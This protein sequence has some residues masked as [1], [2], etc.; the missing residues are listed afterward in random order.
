MLTQHIALVPEAYGL[1][2]SDLA[3]VS[4]ALQKQVTRDFTPIWGISATVDAFPRMEDV[5]IGYWPIVV[6]FNDLGRRAGVHLDRNGQPF[7]LIEVTPCWSLQA[8]RACLEMLVNPSGNRTV[9]TMPARAGQ[10]PA[11]LL[12][13][14]CGPCKDPRYAY[15]I[16]DVL[17]SDFC[18]PA[19]YGESRSV[20]PQRY[21][22]TGAIDAPFQVLPGGHA[23]WYDALTDSWWSK[24]YD[25][26]CQAETKLELGAF[27]VITRHEWMPNVA[28]LSLQTRVM[29]L[30]GLEAKTAERNHRAVLA[31]QMRAHR[32]RADLAAYL[33]D[34]DASQL[35]APRAHEALPSRAA[36]PINEQTV[37]LDEAVAV[38]ADEVKDVAPSS[39]EVFARV[40]SAPPPLPSVAPS[41]APSAAPP[42]RLQAPQPLA[43]RAWTAGRTGVLLAVGA[44]A[45]VGLL[46]LLPTPQSHVRS[47]REANALPAYAS[48]PD[49]RPTAAPAL[50]AA[51]PAAPAIAAA[52]EPTTKSAA[53]R[54]AV[55]EDGAAA[56]VN[57]APDTAN[58]KALERAERRARRRADME[59][60][61][62][63]LAAAV[64]APASLTAAA[65]VKESTH[66]V[67][68]IDDLLNTRQ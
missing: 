12:V 37:T 52:T 46:A 13:E 10:G 58:A 33:H 63:T 20:Q 16:N 44:I 43:D 28:P 23:T 41:M 65:R 47:R 48:E 49:A 36:S 11:E 2:A 22:I 26:D 38:R 61:D 6:S 8:S 62:A 30:Q 59:A 3:R 64:T 67:N 15:D 54:A 50:Q 68:G 53:P 31:G 39:P 17:V 5:P 32:V 60:Q 14:I 34:T 4:A 42:S 35:S 24:T 9:A 40:P 29:Y 18:T 51:T 25:D 56:A 66:D 1:S 27:G 21:S 45:A 55:V 57:E 7:A 19:Y